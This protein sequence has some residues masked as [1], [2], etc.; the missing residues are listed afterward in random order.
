AVD[1]TARCYRMKSYLVLA[2][3]Q[4]ADVPLAL[5]S[6]CPQAAAYAARVT[7]EAVVSASGEMDAKSDHGDVSGVDS[8][9]IRRIA[10]IEL[11]YPGTRP[12]VV[13]EEPFWP[14]AVGVGDGKQ[15]VS[16]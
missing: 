11:G 6:T 14:R 8:A 16:T 3:C 13:S 1:C 12:V 4:G 2:R 5:F 7:P 10:I 9:E 15:A